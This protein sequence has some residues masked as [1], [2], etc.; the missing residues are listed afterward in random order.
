MDI[1]T[2]FSNLEK[3]DKVKE[4][5]VVFGNFNVRFG[6]SSVK[7]DFATYSCEIYE[8]DTL[9]EIVYF[10]KERYL[11]LEDKCAKEIEHRKFL[12]LV[13]FDNQL[14]KIKG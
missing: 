10:D 3:A 7:V 8:D 4:N 1:D 9:L 5:F 11:E 12:R 2:I 13:E 6:V 14:K